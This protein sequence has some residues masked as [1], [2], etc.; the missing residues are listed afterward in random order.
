MPVMNGSNLGRT[1]KYLEIIINIFTP[2]LFKSFVFIVTL[3]RAND[4][5]LKQ[6]A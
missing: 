5:A 4:I 3:S 2:F 1:A 6:S